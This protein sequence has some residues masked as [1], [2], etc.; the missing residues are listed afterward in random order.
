MLHKPTYIEQV[1]KQIASW[2]SE[3]QKFRV[4]AEVADKDDQI[5]HYQ[6]FED[7]AQM[8]KQ[9]VKKLDE[10]KENTTAEWE[11]LVIEIGDL[12]RKVDNAID[13]ARKTIN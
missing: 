3:M 13:A 10:I 4:I 9:V 5:R 11:H 8:E 12:S 7:I 2:N 6:V 1:E